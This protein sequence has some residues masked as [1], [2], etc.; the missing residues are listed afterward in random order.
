MA[1]SFA[2][3]PAPQPQRSAIVAFEQGGFGQDTQTHIPL[4][5]GKLAEVPGVEPTQRLSL[6]VPK[7]WHRR[8]KAACARTDRKMLGEVLE[9]IKQRTVELEQE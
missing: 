3:T 9:F 8:F 7:S 5:V 1:K 4:N 2:Q 6:D